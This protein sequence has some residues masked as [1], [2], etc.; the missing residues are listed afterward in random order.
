MRRRCTRLT[1][2]LHEYRTGATAGEAQG[3]G[4]GAGTAAG[5]ALGQLFA[6]VAYLTLTAIAAALLPPW[7][8]LIE[9][10]CIHI[11]DYGFHCPASAEQHAPLRPLFLSVE[12]LSMDYSA[13][14]ESLET[15]LNAESNQFHTLFWALRSSAAQLQGQETMPANSTNSKRILFISFHR[16]SECNMKNFS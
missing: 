11:N 14:R 3:R 5:A 1:F 9:I 4:P 15:S 7:P 13:P 8:A 16:E 2:T 6:S 12:L 10:N